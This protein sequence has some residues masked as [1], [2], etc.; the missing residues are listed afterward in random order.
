MIS[1][2]LQQHCGG[3][4]AGS[5]TRLDRYKRGGP[6]P[7]PST[8]GSGWAKAPEQNADGRSF[9]VLVNMLE[10]LLLDDARWNLL[11]QGFVERGANLAPGRNRTAGTPT[12]AG[13]AAIPFWAFASPRCAPPSS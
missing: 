1:A 10:H 13:R 8:R 6:I 7:Y 11:R 2:Y 5:L 9:T 3:G 12:P 4:Q